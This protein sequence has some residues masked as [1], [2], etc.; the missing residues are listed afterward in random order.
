MRSTADPATPPEATRPEAAPDPDERREGSGAGP[1]PNPHP[2]TGSEDGTGR[3]RQ[4]CAE[5]VAGP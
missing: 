3:R 4:V 5:F 2:P 1:I